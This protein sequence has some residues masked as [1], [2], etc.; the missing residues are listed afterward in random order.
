M[1]PGAAKAPAAPAAKPGPKTSEI[2]VTRPAPPA[3]SPVKPS[4]A[5]AAAESPVK[6][7][8]FNFDDATILADQKKAVDGD[9][10]GLY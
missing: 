8:F 3:E 10:H 9:G 7:I 5:I 1:G 2:P 4:P 6:D